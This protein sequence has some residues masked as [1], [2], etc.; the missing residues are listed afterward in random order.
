M[1]VSCYNIFIFERVLIIPMAYKVFQEYKNLV[2]VHLAVCK[3]FRSSIRQ[4]LTDK[5][6]ALYILLPYL[7]NHMTD[8]FSY[9]DHD[10]TIALTVVRNT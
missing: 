8:L 1:F 6:F 5:C 10:T 4:L 7:C 9:L 3:S 2:S